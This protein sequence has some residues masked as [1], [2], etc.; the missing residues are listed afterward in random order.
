LNILE[1]RQSLYLKTELVKRKNQELTHQLEQMEQLS[2]VGKAWAMV[3]HEINNLLTPLTTYAQLA[4]TD[5]EDSDLVQKAL[6]KAIRLGNQASE[7][8]Q[9]VP[10]L[11]GQQETRKV[12]YS[13]R[14]LVDDTFSTMARD[15]KKDGIRVQKDIPQDLEVPVDPIGIRQVLMNLI[16]NAREA[17]LPG[18]GRLTITAEAVSGGV[19]IRI[20]DTGC[21]MSPAHMEHIF[22]PFFTTKDGEQGQRKGHGVGLAFCKRVLEN[23][24][25]T[26]R[27]QSKL[28]EGTVFTIG[29]PQVS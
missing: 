1:K 18:G 4:L 16:L 20:S 10:V 29:L 13:V 17:M 21:G 3:A 19:Q 28:K 22:E 12:P 14:Q 6:K 23:H 27:V 25:G 5:P 7:I 8:L 2:V 24:G 15:F 11:A 26:I 9:Q